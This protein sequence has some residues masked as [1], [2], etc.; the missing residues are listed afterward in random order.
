MSV[1]LAAMAAY[2]I[3]GCAEMNDSGKEPQK[4]EEKDATDDAAK[5]SSQ[6]LDIMDLKGKVTKAAPGAYSCGDRNHDK[7]YAVHH[8]WSVYAVSVPD[9]EKAMKRLKEELPQRG[10][11]VTGYGPDSS[12]AKSLQ[13]GAE[14]PERKFKVVITLQDRRGRSK[15]PSILEVDLGSACFQYPDK[16]S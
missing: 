13:L 10:W 14:F 8:P 7:Y 2:S 1:L 5:L 12:R 16:S 15:D 4:R 3:A 11:K 6:I 9:M